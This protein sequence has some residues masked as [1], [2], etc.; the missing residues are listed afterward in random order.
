[1][2]IS[3]LPTEQGFSVGSFMSLSSAGFHGAIGSVFLGG[4]FIVV[5]HSIEFLLLTELFAP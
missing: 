5:I 1:M 4:L 2:G 3:R